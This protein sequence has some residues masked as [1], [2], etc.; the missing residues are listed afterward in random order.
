MKKFLPLLFLTVI[1]VSC[2]V[3]PEPIKYGQDHC[4]FCD[5]T[6]V[7]KAHAAQFVTK[8]G[9]SYSFDSEECL[10]WK[11]NKD[12]NEEKM[13]YILVTDYNSPGTLVDANKATFLISEKIKSPMG[14]NLSAFKSQEEANEAQKKYGGVL[15][16]WEQIKKQ[17][18]K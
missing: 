4:H 3:K 12:Q 2:T 7:D 9:R 15:F 14:A 8:K 17:L 5:M 1:I 18:K 13:A 6:V 10:I 16:N 11:L